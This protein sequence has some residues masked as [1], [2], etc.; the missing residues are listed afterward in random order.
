MILGSLPWLHRVPY[1]HYWEIKH[2]FCRDVNLL[3][4]LSV[5]IFLDFLWRI[6]DANDCP[7][8][9]HVM[10][11]AL[12]NRH[13]IWIVINFSHCTISLQ[14][15]SVILSTLRPLIVLNSAYLMIIDVNLTKMTGK[16]CIIFKWTTFNK[17]Q[18]FSSF[19][20]IGK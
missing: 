14:K 13:W 9:G 17:T 3:D 18:H 2:L 16:V 5:S 8:E 19:I 10:K 6:N 15:W 20:E 7:K 12:S 11:K 4:T 1:T